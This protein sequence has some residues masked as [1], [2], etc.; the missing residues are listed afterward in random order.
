MLVGKEYQQT[1][2][3]ILQ[4][5]KKNCLFERKKHGLI[6]KTNFQICD[7]SACNERLFWRNSD[8]WCL[9]KSITHHY[10]TFSF[11]VEVEMV[12]FNLMYVEVQC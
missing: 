6:G 4:N 12:S 7:D 5:E 2:S 11:I 1:Q 10:T 8:S 9:Y 3:H